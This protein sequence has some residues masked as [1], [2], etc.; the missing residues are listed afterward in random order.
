VTLDVLTPALVV[1]LD[2]LEANLARWQ[3]HCDRAGLANRPHVKTHKCV[4]IARWQVALGA[5]GITCQTLHEAEVMV[6]A[7]IDDLLVPYNVVGE[8]K[9]ERLAS[10]LGRAHLR[11]S[12]DDASLLADLSG[13]AG[14][15]GRELGVLVDC[16]TGL[17]RTGVGSPGEAAGLADEI[18]RT[19]GLRFDGL[20]TFPSPPGAHAFLEAAAAG[21]GAAGWRWR[22]CRPAG[23]RRCGAPATSVPSS[24][25]P[26][27]HVRLQRPEHDPGRRGLARPGRLAVAA[28]VVSRRKGRVIVDAGSKALSSEAA[29]DGFGLVLESP[30]ARIV[31]LD[32]EHGSSSR[33]AASN[34]SSDSKCGSCPTT[35]ASPSTPQTSWWPFATARSRRAGL[36]SVGGDHTTPR[37]IC[38]PVVEQRPVHKMPKEE[39]M[40]ATTLVFSTLT[41][42]FVQRFA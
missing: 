17:G 7:G 31:R 21:S 12:V 16:D 30:G 18:A 20:L 24:R 1:D 6:D 23:P 39:R 32:E 4:E 14:R 11:V 41:P 29:G 36:S 27:R 28:T 10:L 8:P 2:R 3:D 26:R 5:R 22:R 9:L 33:P 19:P 40:T 25:I 35:S 15:A 42:A 13:A 37:T 34:S 38:A